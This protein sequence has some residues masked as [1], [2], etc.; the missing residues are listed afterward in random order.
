MQ[1]AIRVDTHFQMKGWK[2]MKVKTVTIEGKVYA[3][4]DAQNLPVYIHDD[5]KEVGF[6]APHAMQ[7]INTLNGEAKGHR[8]AKE[9]AETALKAFE[10]LD[11]E[12]ARKAIGVVQ[13]LDNKKLIDAGEADR[14]RTEA[15]DS[16]KQ[17]YE[18]Q[19]QEITKQRD[20]F[21][22]DLQNELIG[23]GFSRSDF[24]KQKLSVPADMVQATFGKNFK[25]EDGKPVAYDNNGQK[26]YSRTNHGDPASFDEALDILVSGYQYK[27]SILKGNQGSGGGFKGQGGQGGG[28]SMSRESFEQLKPTERAK[29]FQD[30]GQLTDN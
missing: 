28:K 19:I 15:I 2:A 11:A 23:G 4:V 5:G 10:G 24:I 27:D 30:G 21:Q 20:Q 26:I 7:K 17:T 29:F 12:A 18:T 14:V 16:V 25:I 9:A 8:E 1:T 13:N 3:E 6:D 22:A